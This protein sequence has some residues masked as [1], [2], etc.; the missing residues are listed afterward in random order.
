MR[1]FKMV[2][3]ICIIY[4]LIFAF[5]D[6]LFFKGNKQLNDIGMVLFFI[7]FFIGVPLSLF[8]K[9][10]LKQKKEEVEA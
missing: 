3:T 7:F 8:I 6:I 10:L 2:L 1:I 9:R 5:L 4:L